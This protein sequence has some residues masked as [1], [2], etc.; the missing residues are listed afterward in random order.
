MPEHMMQERTDHYIG[1]GWV[2]SAGAA[3]IDVVSSS[4]EAVIGRGAAGPP[5]AGDRGAAR[6]AR[7]AAGAFGT[8]SG[9]SVEDRA[10]ALERIHAGLEARSK[11]IAE[12][13][14]AE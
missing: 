12:T 8:W 5:A 1:G 7:A 2:P 4:T 9:T 10:A 3:A 11:E 13:I 14:A 6:A